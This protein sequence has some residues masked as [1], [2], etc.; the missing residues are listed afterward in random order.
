MRPPVPPSA[1]NAVDPLAAQKPKASVS[2]S[3]L[4]RTW[5]AGRSFPA[6]LEVSDVL[7]QPPA[8]IGHAMLYLLAALTLAALLWAA[9]S[10]VDVVVDP[11][12]RVV[13]QG[14]VL[15]VQAAQAGSVQVV[16]VREGDVVTRGQKMLDLDMT[17]ARTRLG[18]LREEQDATQSQLEQLQA[19][20]GSFV[21]QVDRQN[22]LGRL[23]SE[24]AT[25]ELTLQR[26]QIVAPTGGV[27]TRLDV[28]TVGAV[29]HSGQLVAAIAPAGAPLVI[30]AHVLNKDVAFVRPGLPVKIK[31]DAFPYQDYGTLDG[32]VLDISPD[33]QGDEEQNSYYKV[34]VGLHQTAMQAGDKRIP[35]RPGLSATAEIV[36]ER[37]SVLALFLEPFR[38]LRRMAESTR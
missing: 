20:H 13:P 4:G 15:P 6:T 1:S 8:W 25:A 29:V 28:H 19:T 16:R 21:D 37:K 10:G 34:T 3:A 36:V 24:I 32:D 7:T 31:L 27:V 33:A 23:Q 22:R 12:G 5:T 2:L 35:L 14:N 26:S 38:K 9:L 18:K 17:E 30:E 11:R